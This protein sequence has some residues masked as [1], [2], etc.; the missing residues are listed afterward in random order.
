MPK[1]AFAARF[2]RNEHESSKLQHT[3]IQEGQLEKHNTNNQP[4]PGSQKRKR[5]PFDEVSE[6]SFIAAS[7]A[8]GTR[9]GT[10]IKAGNSALSSPFCLSAGKTP[11]NTCLVA[12]VDHGNA[13]TSDRDSP[14]VALYEPNAAK[15]LSPTSSFYVD[16][17]AIPLPN[18]N[19]EIV[20]M[21]NKLSLPTTEFRLAE[22]RVWRNP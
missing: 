9:L 15:Q 2:A 16:G 5:P 3:F 21:G 10:S 4:C 14:P 11:S 18:T 19:V 20:D 7:V 22:G 12:A 1:S 8:A 6:P 13:F 17:G